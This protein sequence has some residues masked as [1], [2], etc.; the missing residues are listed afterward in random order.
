MAIQL[1]TQGNSS[2]TY[3]STGSESDG[4]KRSGSKRKSFR[5]HRSLP[6]KDTAGA[7]P[8]PPPPPAPPVQGTGDFQAFLANQ[9]MLGMNSYLAFLGSKR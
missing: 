3:S 8:Q 1:S 9:S 5:R 2:D 6:K 7:L 4:R